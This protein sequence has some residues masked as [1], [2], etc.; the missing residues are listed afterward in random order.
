M[1]LLNVADVTHHNVYSL[2][3]KNNTLFQH[4]FHLIL[5][6]N[7]LYN[8]VLRIFVETVDWIFNLASVYP[9]FGWQKNFQANLSFIFEDQSRIWVS[10]LE[11]KLGSGVMVSI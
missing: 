9:N 6:K 2:Y 7:M 3:K 5:F 4:S 8:F 10:S 11:I 1:A